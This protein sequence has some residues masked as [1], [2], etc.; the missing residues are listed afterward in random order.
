M[1]PW[2]KIER[3]RVFVLHSGSSAIGLG[4]ST[5]VLF[6][7]ASRAQGRVLIGLFESPSPL[8]CWCPSPVMTGG[9]GEEIGGLEG[10][11]KRST[12]ALL[13]WMRATIVS[14]RLLCESDRSLFES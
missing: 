11:G 13:L 7:V 3:L 9:D 8:T 5:A 2:R 1:H 12:L 10:L 14:E 4:R 6:F